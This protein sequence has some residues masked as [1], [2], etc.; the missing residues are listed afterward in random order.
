MKRKNILWLIVLMSL[1]ALLIY[2]MVTGNI[3]Y[4]LHPKMD[5]FI[6]FSIFALTCFSLIEA[7]FLIVKKE[8]IIKDKGVWVFA[9]PVALLI[10]FKPKAIDPSTLQNKV[11]KVDLSNPQGE[12]N[13]SDINQV[14]F[15]N[16]EENKN[17]DPY[18]P[19]AQRSDNDKQ[20]FLTKKNEEDVE[21]SKE[22]SQKRTEERVKTAIDNFGES[23]K[24]Q[25]DPNHK[26]SV[27]EVNPDE[28]EYSRTEGEKFK[29][30]LAKAYEIDNDKEIL[31]ITGFAFKQNDFKDNQVSISRLLMT[32]CVADTSVMGLLS[33]ISQVD[34]YIEVGKWYNFEGSV[35]KTKI[36]N[37]DSNEEIEVPLLL[38]TKAQEIETPISPYVYP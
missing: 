2:L 13:K 35:T 32:C 29:K 15:D 36:F 11:T 21:I 25:N 34:T 5:K 31:S 17:N 24:I 3:R 16:I 28:I 19:P 14:D 23:E 12:K 38:V 8:S 6:I 22:N 20:N 33:D 10:I 4:Y 7:Y 30:T 18:V 9:L 1:D 37:S 27:V 26:P